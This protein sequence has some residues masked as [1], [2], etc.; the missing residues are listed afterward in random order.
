[1][2]NNKCGVALYVKSEITLKRQKDMES[3]NLECIIIYVDVG[4]KSHLYVVNL[5]RPPQMQMSTFQ[6]F[7]CQILSCIPADSKVVYWRL[8]R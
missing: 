5:Y 1:M 4:G 7:L 8:Q 3:D 2:C 6:T